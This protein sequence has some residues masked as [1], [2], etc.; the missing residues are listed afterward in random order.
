MKMTIRSIWRSVFLLLIILFPLAACSLVRQIGPVEYDAVRQNKKTIVLFQ[1]TGSLDGTEVNLLVEHFVA[2][3]FN[4]VLPKIDLANLDTGE[5]VK[6]FYSAGRS[7]LHFSLSPEAA[8]S[9]W[10]A[11]VL[12]PGTYYLRM[13]SERITSRPDMREIIHPIPEFRFIVPPSTPLLYIGS[14]R[15]ACKTKEA[16]SWFGRERYFESCSS[17][18]TAANETEEASTIAL[19]LFSEFGA[20]LSTIMQPYGVSLP[21]GTISTFAP[22]GVLAP[23]IKIELGSPEWMK[24]AIGIGLLPSMGL[25]ALVAGGGGGGPPFGAGAAVALAILGAPVGTVLGYLGGKWSESSWDPCPQA[26]Q[27]SLTK[28]DP[29]EA[30][31]VRLKAA[32]D[33]ANIPTLDIWAGSGAH[34]D[35][36]TKDVKSLLSTQIQRVVLRLCPTSILASRLCSEVATRVRLFEVATQ[37][38]L[39]DRMFVYSD[40]DLSTLKLQPYELAVPWSTRPASARGLEAYCSEGGGEI[41]RGDLSNALDATI[42]GILQDLG[43]RID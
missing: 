8:K 2:D 34:G 26:L 27:D 28:F 38:Y 40:A 41:L 19:N 13:T 33:H 36:I 16:V 17:E 9:G 32:L 43:L 5:P 1:L 3:Y 7:D 37:S 11:F 21:P 39:A 15:L 12:E 35:D 24:R 23:G 31:S 4:R 25:I 30:L 42:N 14:L 22:V 6:S 10:G 18:P 29:I 20:P